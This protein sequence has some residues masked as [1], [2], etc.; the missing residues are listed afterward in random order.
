MGALT[1]LIL[2]CFYVLPILLLID[3]DNGCMMTIQRVQIYDTTFDSLT[4]SIVT[5]SKSIQE[6]KSVE[7]LIPLHKNCAQSNVTSCQLHV[8]NS[9]LMKFAHDYATYRIS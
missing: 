4:E 9:Q 7:L 8:S 2:L 5:N 1:I 3:H 6:E